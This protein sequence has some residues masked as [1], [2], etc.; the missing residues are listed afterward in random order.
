[1]CP[2]IPPPPSLRVRDMADADNMPWHADLRIPRRA[3]SQAIAFINDTT[4]LYRHPRIFAGK[5]RVFK[6]SQ[7]SRLLINRE[8]IKVAE[9][10]ANSDGTVR[11]GSRS[12]S[13]CPSNAKMHFSLH[14]YVPRSEFQ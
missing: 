2:V 8:H 3:E 11:C 10:L 12:T 13:I 4:R 14:L 6:K 5:H 1:M 9:H 7:I